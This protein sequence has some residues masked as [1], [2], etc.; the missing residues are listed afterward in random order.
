M[1]IPCQGAF[2]LVGVARGQWIATY[3]LPGDEKEVRP[4]A[5]P[6]KASA[7]M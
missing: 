7:P 4:E 2:G 5:V 3:A 6:E 1:I